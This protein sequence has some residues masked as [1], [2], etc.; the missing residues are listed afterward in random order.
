MA[1]YLH[2]IQ[3]QFSIE[4]SEGSWRSK[5]TYFQNQRTLIHRIFSVKTKLSDPFPKEWYL[6]FHSLCSICHKKLCI[7]LPKRKK[8]DDWY[9]MMGY[10]LGKYTGT[11]LHK[12]LWRFRNT[13]VRKKVANVSAFLGRRR[14]RVVKVF[15]IQTY[16]NCLILREAFCVVKFLKCVSD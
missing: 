10:N 5:E 9:D 8:K 13:K 1:G 6:Y 3:L 15:V 11:I 14:W 4:P 16:F 12:N 7:F 2:Y